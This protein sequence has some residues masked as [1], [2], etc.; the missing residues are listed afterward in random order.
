[1]AKINV[2]RTYTE[3]DCPP[4]PTTCGCSKSDSC[5]WPI[6]AGFGAGAVSGMMIGGGVGGPAGA[7][8]GLIVGAIAGSVGG[9]ALCD[10]E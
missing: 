2:T 5:D 3:R 4:C 7:L 6:G 8:V 10:E 9:A 1:M